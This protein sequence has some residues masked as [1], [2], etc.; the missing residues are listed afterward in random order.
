MID[1]DDIYDQWLVLCCQ[2][3]DEAALAEIVDRWQ[4]R[5]LRQALR[6]T[7]NDEGA[8][9]AVQ[10]AW[11]AILSGLPKLDDP[12]CFRRWAYQIVTYKCADW[13]RARQSERT[14][15]APLTKDP[16]DQLQSSTS[17]DEIALLRE[18]LK[19]LEPEERTVLSMFY[20]D[21]LSLREVATALGLPEGTVKSRLHYA[22]LKLKQTIERSKS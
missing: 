12:A 4:P 20:L 6:L 11:L 5:L 14:R 22:R 16:T 10:A 2:D 21:G 17:H 9:E 8:G 3:G 1:P 13:I 15:A 18:S 19:R 7:R